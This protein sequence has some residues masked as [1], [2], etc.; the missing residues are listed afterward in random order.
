M[1]SEPCARFTMSMMPKISVRP[2]ATR[3]S[4]RPS[5]RPFRHCSRTRSIDNPRRHHPPKRMTPQTLRS[6]DAPQ[7]RGMT[8]RVSLNRPSSPLHRTARVEL[9][10]AVLDDGRDGLEREVAL[11]VLHHVLQ[12][13]VLDRE[14][15]V[16]VAVG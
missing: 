13:E 15:V 8:C 6:L 1:Y 11:G 9:V 12:I 16:A 4:S 2:A 10:L 3:N 7:A 14:V 5:C